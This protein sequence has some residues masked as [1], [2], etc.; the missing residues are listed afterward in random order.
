MQRVF[1]ILTV[2]EVAYVP[3]NRGFEAVADAADVH[4]LEG[5]RW[6]VQLSKSGHAYAVARINGRDTLMHRL[7]LKPPRGQ[8]VDHINS[9][10]LDNR[11]SNIRLCTPSQNLANIC[12]NR[13]NTVGIKGVSN[14]NGKYVA[15]IQCDKKTYHLGAFATKEEAGAAYQGAAKV[16][17]GQFFRQ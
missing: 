4:L 2:S 6:R 10:G 16:L 14:K 5:H 1:S 11:R 3:L 7:I 15:T 13:R 12:A 9:D 17:F 8:W